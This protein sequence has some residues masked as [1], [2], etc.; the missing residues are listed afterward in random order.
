MIEKLQHPA[1]LRVLWTN[2]KTTSIAPRSV[3]LQRELNDAA[4][5]LLTCGTYRRSTYASLE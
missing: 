4:D 3:H 5:M 2:Q 1:L